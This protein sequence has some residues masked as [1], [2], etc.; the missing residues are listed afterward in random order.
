MLC[1]VTWLED[2]E[3]EW[4]SAL[5]A[6]LQQYTN[7]LWRFFLSIF[8]EEQR[9]YTTQKLGLN[10]MKCVIFHKDLFQTKEFCI[11]KLCFD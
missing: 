5:P 1:A 4:S 2:C 10:S 9:F 8:L 3:L 11:A 7:T 6:S